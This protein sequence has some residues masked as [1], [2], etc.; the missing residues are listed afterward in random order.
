M[1]YPPAFVDT[2]PKPSWINGK[3]ILILLGII[4]IGAAGAAGY[5]FWQENDPMG[6][7]EIWKTEPLY[8]LAGETRT[9]RGEII[10]E[11][12]SDF[13]FNGIFIADSSV[14]KEALSPQTG[15]WFGIRIEGVT[16]DIDHMAKL[17][18]CAPFDP[19]RSASYEFKGTLN[20][21]T[22]GK[23]A[24]LW[25]SDVDFKHSRQ[26]VNGE[27]QAI[28]LGEFAIPLGNLEPGN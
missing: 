28:P 23:K 6:V 9:V 5:R 4:L 10:F 15:F 21:E 8:S 20:V 22:V 26:L 19:T 18:T 1:K 27:W 3:V 25:L 7:I 24:I 13:T 2:K 14:P 17:V 12:L 16:C 11:P